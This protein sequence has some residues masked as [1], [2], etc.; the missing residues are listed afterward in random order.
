MK[1]TENFNKV[2]VNNTVKPVDFSLCKEIFEK[3]GERRLIG[4]G[5]YFARSGEVME[6]AGWIVSGG[7]KYS[8]MSSDGDNRVIG[9]SLDDS[10]LIDYESV[11]HFTKMRTDIIALEDSE[12]IVIP[13]KI[14][15]EKLNRDHKL[16]INLMMGLFEQLYDHFLEFCRHTPAQR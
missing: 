16:N 12:V 14:L 4:R 15:R 8:L 5:E 13:A 1:G 6:Y 2:I 11:M 9:F 3:F 10:L 7:F